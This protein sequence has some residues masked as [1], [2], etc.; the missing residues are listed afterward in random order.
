MELANIGQTTIGQRNAVRNAQRTEIVFRI[1]VQNIYSI[2][3]IK[4][5]LNETKSL[6]AMSIVS[7]LQDW[8][9]FIHAAVSIVVVYKSRLASAHWRISRSYGANLLVAFDRKNAFR[10]ERKSF[11]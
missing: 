4:I 6:V 10:I 9:R 3:F 11:K 7:K 8:C 5:S 1:L 2:L